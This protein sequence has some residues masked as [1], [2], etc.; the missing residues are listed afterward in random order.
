MS[1]LGDDFR[2]WHDYK[3]EIKQASR[4]HFNCMPRNHVGIPM[5]IR[6]KKKQWWCHYCR[7]V[8]PATDEEVKTMEA[9]IYG[10]ASKSGMRRER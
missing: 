8:E 2:D 4:R 7:H 5:T 1:E 6:L 10:G 3:S 9:L